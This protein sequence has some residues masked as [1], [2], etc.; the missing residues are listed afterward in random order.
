MDNLIAATKTVLNSYA[1][2][3][4]RSG[5]VEFWWYVLAYII[6]AVLVAIVE[7]IIG[8]GDLLSNI[9]ALA[10]LVPSIAVSVR[11]LHDIGKSGWWYLINLIPLVGWIVFIYWAAQPSGPAN[12]HGEGPQPL[13]S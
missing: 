2:F 6:I 13:A 8:L 11:R 5:R 3:E 1:K 10:L 4:G 12:E 7:G 9:L